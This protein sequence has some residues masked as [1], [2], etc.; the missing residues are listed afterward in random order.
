MSRIP[1]WTKMIKSWEKYWDK[2]K[3]FK[4]VYKG[5]PDRFRGTVWAKLLYLEQIKEEQKGKYE[6]GRDGGFSPFEEKKKLI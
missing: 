4:R 5:I 3:F 2:E 6:V 1:K